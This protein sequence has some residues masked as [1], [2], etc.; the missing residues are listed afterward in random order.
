MVLKKTLISR[1]SL[2][3]TIYMNQF[4]SLQFSVG[5]Q[6]WLAF[7]IA[8]HW[9]SDR[10]PPFIGEVVSDV[11]YNGQ[12]QSNPLHPVPHSQ[13]S[14]WFAHVSNSREQPHETSQHVSALSM[15]TCRIG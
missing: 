6:H 1:A 4:C 5:A 8:H 7:I 14:C 11:V 13:P 10:M 9:H 2:K 3:L 12:L 15:A